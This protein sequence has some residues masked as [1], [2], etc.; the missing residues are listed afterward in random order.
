MEVAM[1]NAAVGNADFDFLQ[2]QFSWVITKRQKFGARCV[3]C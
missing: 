2:A 3:S 1:T